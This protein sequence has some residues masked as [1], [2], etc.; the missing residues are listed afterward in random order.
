MYA[1]GRVG[2]EL[3]SKVEFVASRHLPRVTVTRAA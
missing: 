2:V 1:F 3:Y